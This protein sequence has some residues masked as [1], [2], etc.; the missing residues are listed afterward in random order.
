MVW[1][2]VCVCVCG[3]GGGGG[4]GARSNRC[5][6]CLF[7][8][9]DKNPD[10]LNYMAK[11]NTFI[12]NLANLMHDCVVIVKNTRVQFLIRLSKYWILCLSVLNDDK[13]FFLFYLFI[14]WSFFFFFFFFVF[15]C[16]FLFFFF[17]FFF[18]KCTNIS[19][20]ILDIYAELFLFFIKRTKKIIIKTTKWFKGAFSLSFSLFHMT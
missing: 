16:F 17:F 9:S 6:R 7:H 19:T 1:R 18:I 4:G 8:C 20:L 11:N 10:K 12:F 13:S 15:F 5:C 2:E 14:Y 3:G